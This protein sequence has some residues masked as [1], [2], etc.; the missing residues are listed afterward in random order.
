MITLRRS[1]DRGSADHGWLKAK[2][3][4]SFSSYYD[5]A[6]MG[7]RALRVINEDRVAEKQ[8]FP[9]HGHKDM[10]II[11]YII[12]G[13]LEHKDSM[14]NGSIIKP[15]D[16][17]YMSAGT[18]VRHSEFNPSQDEKVHLLQIWVE[19]DQENY[20]PVYDQKAFSKSDRQNTLK[21]VATGNAQKAAGESV[22][23]IR[24]DTN[25]YASLLEKNKTVDF[26][27]SAGRGIWLQL[28]KGQLVVNDVAA[29]SG[30]GLKIENESLLKINC[31]ED[32]EF[33]MFDLK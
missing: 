18:G 21:L 32:A 26:T 5:E 30:D 10:E 28:V 2:H 17:Q 24:Q 6:H 29:S 31:Q 19:P 33:L 12:S 4:F 22:I 8:G 23:K 9:T 20:T 11:T 13:R 27:P 14:G 3:S 16:V 1:N 25:I 7:F 15:G